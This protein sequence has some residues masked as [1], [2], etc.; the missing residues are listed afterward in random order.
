MQESHLLRIL[1]KRKLER[2]H[3]PNAEQPRIDDNELSTDGSGNTNAERTLE[4]ESTWI[5]VWKIKADMCEAL[6][7][8]PC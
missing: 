4:P 6:C 8:D 1:K 5:G 7:S 2:I 3:H